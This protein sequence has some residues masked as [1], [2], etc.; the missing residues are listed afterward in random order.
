MATSWLKHLWKRNGR[1]IRNKPFQG[2]FLPAVEPLAERVLPTV[3]A[4]VPAGMHVLTVHGDATNNTIV[5][6]RDTAGTILVNGS[7]VSIKGHQA[8]VA[9]I[10]LIRVYGGDGN[11][12]IT[13]DESN[14]VL[15]AANLYGGEGNDILT[16]G[17]GNDKL[18]GQAGNDSLF[19]NA[20]IDQLFG[21]AGNDELTGGVGNDRVFG[22]AGDDRM[23]WNPGDASDLNEGGDGMDTVEVNG[24]NVSEAFTVTPNGKRVR[25]DR[26][27]PAPFSLDIGTS[28][29]LVVNANGGDD[30][31]TGANGLA[32]LISLAFDGGDGNDSLTGGDGND[33]I[34]GGR[35]SDI[36]MLGAGDD[37]FVW[38]PGDGSDVVEGGDGNDALVFNG[39]DVNENI[40]LSAN[41]DR[42]KLFRDVGNVTMDTNGVERVAVNV[43][44]GADTVTLN[45]LTGTDV[46]Q[47]NVDL[48]APAGSGAGDGQADTVTVNATNADDTISIAGYVSGVSVSGLS[49]QVHIVGAEAAN[50]RL[51]VNAMN[52]ND[53]VDGTGLAQGAIQLT[54]DGG[55]GDDVLL[56]GAGD[57]RLDGRAGNDL[58]VGGPGLDILDGGPGTNTVIQ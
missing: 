25:F 24:G 15:P 34:I 36:A 58:L 43:Q 29:R 31:V 26:T 32:P 56:G 42:F 46:T 10:L 40:S 21:G 44:G 50:D 13:L 37:T 41:G 3:T 19:G 54:A 47:V 27:S 49:A 18:Y 6:S 7:A 35:G 1:P 22:Q 8:T 9:N 20:G 33:F 52:G 30:T 11:D 39:A 14:G 5:I 16:G 28:E 55:D 23:K 57:D 38:N 51:V 45:D 17:D 2:R 53:V 4:S 48:A 12:Q